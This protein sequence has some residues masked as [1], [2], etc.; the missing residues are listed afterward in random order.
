MDVQLS[1]IIPVYNSAQRL[2]RLVSCIM[3]VLDGLGLSYEIILVDDGS[4]DDS[5]QAVV[6]LA[7]AHRVVGGLRLERNLGQNP[8]V[9]AGL[10]V[11]RGEAAV[12]LDDDFQHPPQSIP[13]LLAAYGPEVD[14]VYAGPG[15]SI[16]PAL[17]TALT[18]L[19]RLSLAVACRAPFL[20]KMQTF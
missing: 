13:A 4:A 5:W 18:R 2:P 16:H 8:A 11:A 15:K 19:V 7:E 6:S 9:I 12:T 17:Y 1:I 10:Q 3:E 14:L 20:M